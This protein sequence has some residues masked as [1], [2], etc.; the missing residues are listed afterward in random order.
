MTPKTATIIVDMARD[1]F[2]MSVGIG[3]A[4]NKPLILGIA[5]IQMVILTV[6]QMFVKRKYLRETNA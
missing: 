1:A 4:T 5:S 2:W 6:I 3:I